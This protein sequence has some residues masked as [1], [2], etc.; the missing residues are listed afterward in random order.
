MLTKK[1]R[2][3]KWR[4]PKAEDEKNHIKS[5]NLCSEYVGSVGDLET[6]RA[7]FSSP[8]SKPYKELN[9]YG[10]RGYGI[11]VYCKL[12]IEEA[13]DNLPAGAV[14]ER[15]LLT[16]LNHIL[17]E[18]YENPT[19]NT[20]QKFNDLIATTKQLLEIN[21]ELVVDK[22]L[23]KALCFDLYTLL[24]M[25]NLALN[26]LNWLQKIAV[27]AVLNVNLAKN[28]ITTLLNMTEIKVKRLDLFMNQAHQKC[29]LRVN[30]EHPRN[31]LA[32]PSENKTI[33]DYFNDEFLFLLQTDNPVEQK[34]ELLE[35]RLDE[36]RKDLQRL[37]AKR[38]A[39]EEI[40]LK[41]EKIQMLLTPIIAN[42]TKIKHYPSFV[43]LI[44]TYP[45]AMDVLIEHCKGESKELLIQKIAQINAP[46]NIQNSFS[47]MLYGMSTATTWMAAT[48][49]SCTPQAVQVITTKIPY[50]NKEYIEQL[51]QAGQECIA[52]LNHEYSILDRQ[53]AKCNSQIAREC[54][55]LEQL[56]ACETTDNLNMLVQGNY[57]AKNALHEYKRISEFLLGAVWHLHVIAEASEVLNNFV[58]KNNGFLVQISN[59]FAHILSLFKTDTATMIDKAL[60]LQKHLTHFEWE[61][62]KELIK[63]MNVIE[64]NPDIEP[65]L[66]ISLRQ[67][68]EDEMKKETKII[69][70]AVPDKED[71]RYLAKSLEQLYCIKND[72]EASN[73]SPQIWGF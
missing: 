38:N 37:I 33:Q 52:S 65:S 5:A 25:G 32:S 64:Q 66:K 24:S 19:Y 41:I 35:E 17:E 63:E 57:A 69:P 31:F 53:I 39:K 60:E 8:D 12:E 55:E 58:Q 70:Y 11:L 4:G 62:K 43:K 59:F 30:Q 46:H 56:I 20:S 49:R 21:H 42:D 40:R 3:V 13:L 10:E 22:K 71:I 34:L 29:S 18:T 50:L 1:E 26:N 16:R 14:T 45:E 36:V 68:V 44:K 2:F 6:I 73:T 47:K 15:L 7:D 67:Q 48:Y 28:E 23:A 61:Y 27:N 9:R 51:K 54:S 72:V